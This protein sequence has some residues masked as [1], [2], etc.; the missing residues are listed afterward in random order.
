VNSQNDFVQLFDFREQNT[1]SFKG[2]FQSLMIKFLENHLFI[3]LTRQ[4]KPE[5][6]LKAME[7]FETI[8]L[9]T[10]AKEI[11]ENPKDALSSVL[12][13]TF[14]LK[15][16]PIASNEESESVPLLPSIIQK[17]KYLVLVDEKLSNLMLLVREKLMKNGLDMEEKSL[18]STED[19][20]G[21]DKVLICLKQYGR[22]TTARI[23]FITRVSLRYGKL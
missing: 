18:L 22:I 6:I 23:D 20:E 8:V 2:T 14:P 19:F 13:E 11:H 16:L 17:V 15:P 12:R 3:I 4:V 10:K 1:K 5:S 9:Y 21:Y 7:G